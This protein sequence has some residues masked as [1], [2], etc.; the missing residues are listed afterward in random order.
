VFLLPRLLTIPVPATLSP[1]APDPLGLDQPVALPGLPTDD[2]PVNAIEVE[3]QRADQ[4][5]TRKEACRRRHLAEVVDSV[6]VVL[7][8]HRISLSVKA[9]R[10]TASR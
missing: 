5:L 1:Y 2:H 10:T 6:G 3:P 7:V 4:G 8:L 9:L